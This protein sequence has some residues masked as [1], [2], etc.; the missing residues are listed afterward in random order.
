MNLNIVRCEKHIETLISCLL[1]KLQIKIRA[2][3]W[4]GVY[5]KDFYLNMSYAFGANIITTILST[6][7]V[8]FLPKLVDI[9]EYGAIQLML[10]YINYIGFLHFGLPEGFILGMVVYD[11]RI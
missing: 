5:T 10:F 3:E 8:M 1:Q 11:M 4:V 2:G 7:F 9:R 6:I